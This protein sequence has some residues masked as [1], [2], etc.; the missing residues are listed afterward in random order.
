LKSL[1][2]ENITH[3]LRSDVVARISDRQVS[4]PR[5]ELT[6]VRRLMWP[7]IAIAAALMLMFVQDN[8]NREVDK[9]AK[10]EAG[11]AQRRDHELVG[12]PEAA[13]EAPADEPVT[14]EAAA[15]PAAPAPAA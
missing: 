4:L 15:Q 7:A 6:M 14:L 12:E 2:R 5:V 13:F 10:V 11:A 3:D 9:V 8:Q 1:P